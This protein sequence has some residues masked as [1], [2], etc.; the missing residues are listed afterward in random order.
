[1]NPPNLNLR[2]PPHLMNPPNL[3][4]NRQSHLIKHPNLNL[5]RP[6]LMIILPILQKLKVEA[7]LGK[8]KYGKTTVMGKMTG[9]QL[10]D[11]LSF[12]RTIGQC[13]NDLTS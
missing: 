5:N 6:P 13:I 2:R 3:N 8:R 9:E 1:M 10:S 4:L 12:Y 7:K 11:L